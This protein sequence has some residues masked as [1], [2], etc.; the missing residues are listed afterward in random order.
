MTKNTST[1]IAAWLI[2]L[3][4][5]LPAAAEAGVVERAFKGK[6]VTSHKRIP[7]SSKSARLYVRKLKKQWKKKFRENKTTKQWKIHYAAFFRKPLNDL[8]VTVKLYDVTEGKK[9]VAAFEQ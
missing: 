6:I 7:T 3:A 4:L 9:L 5:C 2:A 8:E 1:T